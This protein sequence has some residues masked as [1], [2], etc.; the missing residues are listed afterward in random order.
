MV[1]GFFEVEGYDVN[2]LSNL[3]NPYKGLPK[4]IYVI[5]IARIIN[6]M[7]CFVMPLM[8]IILTEKI[9]LSRDMAG[10]Y[11][12]ASQLLCMPAALIGGKLADTI[13][14]K[15]LI[16]I[17][18]SLAAVLYII[19]G[20]MTPSIPML[21]VLTAACFCMWL[22][23]P[24]HDSI[25]ADLTTPDNRN[26]SYAL[27]Y[28]GWNIGFAVG[29]TVGGLLYKNHLP[30]VFIGDALTALISLGL[31]ATFIKETIHKTR[32]D[33]TD[34][35][36]ILERREEGSIISVLL[37]RPILIYFALIVF[38]YNFA[39][40]QWSFLMPIH[41]VQNF[42]S[43]GAQYFGWMASFNGIVVMLFT[44]LITKLSDKMNN[45]RRMVCGGLL[46]AVGF[47]ML[48]ILNSLP[49]FFLSVLIFT[50]G[51][52]ILSISTMPFIA[53]H[54]PASHR[55][56]MNSILPMI[57]GMG[58][59]LGPLAMGNALT[60]I[61]IENAWLFI[62]ALLIVASAFMHVLERYEKRTERNCA[63]E[64]LETAEE[65]GA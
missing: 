63:D 12:S 8:A 39:Y 15:F 45:M 23:G 28:M 56:R 31:I 49:F 43:H 5:F 41:S 35:N 24:A 62:G 3:L 46:Y 21:G 48:G 42:S 2:K 27:S 59:T 61:S 60:F 47:G 57:L 54:T 37:K 38:W 10:L 50:W 18:D 13:G 17:F 9:G 25:I 65:A 7:G 6:G 55:G 16:V 36:R 14:R 33:I 4:E 34:E 51:E 32:E 11:V 29:P 1:S 64:E 58:Y 26:G 19:C 30:L 52:I 22:A 20:L 40:A 53:N 44:P